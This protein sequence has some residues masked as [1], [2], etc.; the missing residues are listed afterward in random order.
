MADFVI[1]DLN[2]GEFDKADAKPFAVSTKKHDSFLH[3]NQFR[4]IEK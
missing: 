2:F 4:I 3:S 1:F